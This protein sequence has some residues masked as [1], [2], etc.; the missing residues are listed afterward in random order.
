[1]LAFAYLIELMAVFR[2][3]GRPEPGFWRGLFVEFTDLIILD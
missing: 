1:M 2:P 3:M